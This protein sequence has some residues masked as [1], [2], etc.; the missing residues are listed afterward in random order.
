MTEERKRRIAAQ[1]RKRAA[2][3]VRC[4]ECG[5]FFSEVGIHRHLR[6]AECRTESYRQALNPLIRRGAQRVECPDCG[7]LITACRLHLHVRSKSCRAERRKRQIH[8]I[9]KEQM[10]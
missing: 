4:P 9:R 10:P 1:A 3:R 6:S 7:K 5:L 8:T 2:Y